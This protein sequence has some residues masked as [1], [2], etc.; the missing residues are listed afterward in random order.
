MAQQTS[1]FLESKYGWNFGESFWNT[2][3]DENM[4]KFS[5]M[6]DRN[7]DSIVASLPAAVNGQ[8]HYLTT[9]NRLY[10]AVGTTYFSSPVPK[11]FTVVVRTTGQTHQFNGTSLAQVDSPA[12]LDSRL[13][14]VELTVSTLGTAAFQNIA[15]FA[16]QAGLDVA[17]AQANTY[18]DTLRTDVANNSLATKGAALI[19]FD[20]TTLD[21]QIK[22]KLNRVVDSIVSLKALDKTK[23]T[24]A[25]VTGYYAA[26]DGGGGDYLH[27]SAD[28]T[29]GAYVTGSI[30]TTTL[31]VT[32]VTNGTLAVGQRISGTG[33]TDSTY[34][35][36]LGTG[37][38]GTGTYTVSISQ[39]V[40]S[41]PISADNGGSL[42]VAN[43]GGRWKLV[44]Q[45][46]YTIEQ[47]GAKDSTDSTFA[48][49]SAATTGKSLRAGYGNFTINS[50]I[51]IAQIF[52]CSGADD[53]QTAFT[54][55]GTGQFVIGDFHAKFDNFLI[56][57][58]VNNLV[59]IRNPGMSFF[60]C[61]NFRAE[62]IGAATGQVAIEF[63]TTIASIYFNNV[64]HFKIKLDY[65]IRISGNST[66]V[67]NAN[68]IGGRS[69]AYYQDFQSAITN[70]GQLAADAN[71]FA[72]YFE[73]GT[74]A[75][76]HVVGALRQN[77][78]SMVIDAVTRAYNGGVAVTATNVWE[79]LDG[80]FT[81]GGTYPQ[82]QYLIGPPTTKVYASATD[83]QSISNA[84]VTTVTWNTETTDTLS[85]FS[86]GTGVFTAKNAGYYTVVAR[87]QTASVAWPLGSRFEL[88]VYKNGSEV[89]K[90]EWSA[91]QA[92][93][94][95]QLSSSISTP[96]ILLNGTTD[97]LDV[98]V[99][100]NQGGAVTLDTDAASNYI[101]IT[102]NL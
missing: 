7:I 21:Q 49:K 25:F 4:L 65:P 6:F 12:Q 48:I 78:F 42:I 102:R 54:L 72:G 50:P 43:D 17:S 45:G 11:W 63:D 27:D 16:T 58:A 26:L 22:L 94:T 64:N 20:S 36:A 41:T 88:R 53:G 70:D 71:V 8:A 40:S 28:T 98:R 56:K 61:T 79:I 99:I 10:F 18:T 24:R 32:S 14:A 69:T 67:F 101:G 30:S 97:T 33:V 59:F 39:T 60:A 2:G 84:T 29:S 82:N 100:H 31:T 73:T 38:G 52:Q 19:G 77:H 9:D 55:T 66:Q 5:F 87:T 90:G 92:A 81:T 95:G 47:F 1:P 44:F 46:F 80:G 15:F 37:T 68:N 83:A 85:E 76:N 51:T 35:T 75:F 13:D 57:S 74:N 89:S 23:Y 3:M 34:I 91:A 96:P 93:F 62:K 86:N